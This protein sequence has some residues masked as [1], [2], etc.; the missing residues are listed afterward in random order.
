M[1]DILSI[2][3]NIQKETDDHIALIKNITGERPDYYILYFRIENGLPFIELTDM[4]NNTMISK[5]HIK[6]INELSWLLNR[7]GIL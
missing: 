4:Y 2:G 3:F 1:N 6:N 5:I 7:Y